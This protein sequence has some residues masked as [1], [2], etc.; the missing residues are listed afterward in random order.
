MLFRSAHCALALWLAPG[1]AALAIDLVSR[2]GGS[3]TFAD[4]PTVSAALTNAG[5]ERHVMDMVGALDFLNTLPFVV[6]GG[7]GVTGYCYGGGVAW[8]IAVEDSRVVAA[9]PYYGI[10]P[11]LEKVPDM[12][13]AVRGVYA[14][15]DERVNS[16]AVPLE[17]MLRESGK[18]YAMKQYPDT[19]HGFF[20]DTSNVY[21]PEQAQAA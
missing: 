17:L 12:R 20:G 19:R 9:V 15:D 16:T 18:T 10:A 13:A 6:Q 1:F 5:I 7:Q 11:P 21:A 4:Q 2:E 14:S 8:R 3:A